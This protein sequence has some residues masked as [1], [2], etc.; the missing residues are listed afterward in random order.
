VSSA[1]PILGER[2]ADALTYAARAHRRQVRKGVGIP[3]IAHLLGV[4]SLVIEGASEDG[5]L[6][7]DLAIAALLH[8]VAEDQ[9]GE[10]RIEDVRARFGDE[11]A[12]I[13]E[14]CSD[15]LTESPDERPP[16]RERKTAYLEHLERADP[17]VL[18]VSLADKL[19]NARAIVFDH[20]IHGDS[21]WERFNPDADAPWYYAALRDVFLR[22]L[23]GPQAD[24]LARV[25]EELT[26][27]G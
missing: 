22:R 27:L 2:F 6:T 9:G 14:A 13:V 7:E 26:A 20:R 17:A 23:P 5:S 19:H 10:R 3:Y 11:V 8:D 21:L 25:V 15:S 24:E 12:R 18:R 4:A 16:W 1:D